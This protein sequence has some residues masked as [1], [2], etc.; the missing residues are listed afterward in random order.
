MAAA[1]Q[2]LLDALPNNAA[3]RLVGVGGE[4]DAA[5]EALAFD[6]DALAE[7]LL[8]LVTDT[9]AGGWSGT[10]GSPE[11]PVVAYA[12]N[13]LVQAGNAAGT[14]ILIVDGAATLRGRV[15]WT[16]LVVLRPGA[17]AA[18][19][20]DLGGNTAVT[21][22]VLVLGGAEATLR[23]GGSPEVRYS[24]A[25]FEMLRTAFDLPS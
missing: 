17:S 24:R 21:G 6:A 3:A 10:L 14:G 19:A 11:A 20:L 7:H 8:T 1:Q 15:R 12:P 22:G 18:P 2:R 25:A 23:L 13:G 16:G 4:A 9:L 5:A